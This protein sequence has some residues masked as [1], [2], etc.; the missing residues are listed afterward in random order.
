M[1]NRMAYLRW[2]AKKIGKPRIVRKDNARYGIGTD[3]T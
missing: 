3:G 1:R 2:L